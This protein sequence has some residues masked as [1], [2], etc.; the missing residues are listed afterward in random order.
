MKN[1]IDVTKEE[2]KFSEVISLTPSKEDVFVKKSDLAELPGKWTKTF[3]FFSHINY[4]SRKLVQ[5]CFTYQHGRNIKV[6][7]AEDHVKLN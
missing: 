6:G 5:A 7:S 4:G 1:V 2:L 3:K